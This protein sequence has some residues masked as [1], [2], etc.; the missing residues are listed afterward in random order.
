[1]NISLIAQRLPDFIFWLPTREKKIVNE[2]RRLYGDFPDNLIVRI[3]AAMIDG[4]PPV[5][6][7]CTSTVHKDKD[8][9]GFACPARTQ[10]NQCGSCRA[11]WDKSIKNISYPEH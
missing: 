4:K 10:G 3:S 6:D 7:L 5:T 9:V 8:P 11:C 1:M 2:Y